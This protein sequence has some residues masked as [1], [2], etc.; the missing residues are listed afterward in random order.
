MHHPPT[1]PPKKNQGPMIALITV[2]AIVVLV[3]IS[4]FGNNV[5]L[6]SGG[7]SGSFPKAEYQLTV[8]ATLLDGKYKLSEDQSDKHQDMLVGT[9]EANIRDTKATVAQYLSASESDVLIVSGMYGR[10][11]DPDEARSRILKGATES[12]GS[13]IAVP[14][15]DVT[16][17]GSEVTITCQVLTTEQA[18]GGTS[19]LPMCAWAD[20]NTNAAVALVTPDVAAQAPEEVDLT[21]AAEATAKV[22]EEMRKPIG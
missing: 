10:I 19:T 3:A 16:P 7:G 4:W 20:D 18:D 15:M 9:S 8:P 2:A 17:T 1:P 11:K 5:N 13:T 14:A 22:R 21:A 6:R 12:D